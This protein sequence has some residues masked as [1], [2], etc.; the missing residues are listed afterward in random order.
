M[1]I[2]EFPRKIPVNPPVMK[3]ETNPIAN[4]I[5][6]V[7]RRFPFHR[8]VIQLNTLTAEGT[9]MINVETTK[10]EATNGFNPVTNMWWAQTMNDSPAI[11]NNE[12]TIA[13]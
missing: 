12:K 4:N 10:I 2:A 13:L 9:A 5:P 7:S 8:V 1:S 6:G 3:S 11:N